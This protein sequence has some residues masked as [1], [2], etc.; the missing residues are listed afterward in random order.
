MSKTLESRLGRLE[1]RFG[2]RA[3][4]V[5]YYFNN[6]ETFEQ[7]KQRFKEENGYK[8]P[9]HAIVICYRR[10]DVSHRADN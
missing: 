6:E 1:A 3:I 10:I 4:T 2:Q 9:D 7:R 8:L 5:I